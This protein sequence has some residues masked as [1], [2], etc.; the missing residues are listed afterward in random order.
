M[1]YAISSFVTPAEAW[2]G[3]CHTTLTVICR[4]APH[5]AGAVPAQVGVGGRHPGRHEGGELRF[6][7]SLG[8]RAEVQVDLPE[9]RRVG[10][11]QGYRELPAGGRWPGGR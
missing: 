1:R 10:L 8:G 11:G 6:A 7:L 3:S 4:V 5:L 2:P 9:L